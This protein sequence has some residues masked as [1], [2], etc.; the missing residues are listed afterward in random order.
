MAHGPYY[1]ASRLTRILTSSD[2]EPPDGT[3]VLDAS[4]TKWELYAD[5]GYWLRTEGDDDCADPESWTKVAGNY[6]PVTVLEEG[7]DDG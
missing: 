3:I 7:D 5:E 2:P 6:G 1:P 4:G